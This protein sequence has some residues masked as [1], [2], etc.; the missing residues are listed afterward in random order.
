[1]TWNGS[2]QVKNHSFAIHKTQIFS[3]EC[4][5]A[6]ARDALLLI[7]RKNSQVVSLNHA[8][9]PDNQVKNLFRHDWFLNP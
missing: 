1:M 3:D 8:T 9:T 7:D 4:F 2:D 5:S 6:A